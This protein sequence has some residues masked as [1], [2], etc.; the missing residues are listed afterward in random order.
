MDKRENKWERLLE[1][2]PDKYD[3][4]HIIEFAPDKLKIKAAEKLLKSDIRFFVDEAHLMLRCLPNGCQVRKK[5]KTM[6]DNYW[7][8]PLSL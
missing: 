7:K 4:L 1:N 5:I 3:L 2:K 8:S 6:L